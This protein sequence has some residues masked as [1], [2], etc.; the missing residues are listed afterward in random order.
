MNA[1]LHIT[2]GRLGG[3]FLIAVIAGLAAGCAV[4][5]LEPI[6]GPADTELFAP[7]SEDSSWWAVR[8][9]M[10]RPEGDTRWE[11]DLLIAHRIILPLTQAYRNDLAL[12]RFHR[13]SAADA[14][15]HQFSFIFFASAETAARINRS[16]HADPM[17]ARL[18]ATRTVAAV[19]TDPGD[20]RQR[21]E[22][23]DTS[24]PNW[25][26]LMQDN[27]PY[28]IMGVSRM[29]LGMIDQASRSIGSG[30]TAD[31][32]QLVTH[33]AAVNQTITRTWQAESYHAL[34]HHLNA[35]FGYEAMIFHE[36]SWKTF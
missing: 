8:F 14:K 10:E 31:I 21:P 1:K 27:W 17:V 33:Y 25:S 18:L 16:I 7:L 12:W 30:P 3:V 29:W 28:F 9:A 34:L 32:Q 23:G 6:P 24:D 2:M 22:V 15:G 26:P 4:T 19:L 36:K 35:L 11:T 20:H 13:R 5:S